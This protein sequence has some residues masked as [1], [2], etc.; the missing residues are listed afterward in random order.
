MSAV[1]PGRRIAMDHLERLR[2]FVAV[3]DTQSFAGAARRL[4]CSAP[5]ATRAIAALEQRLG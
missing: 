3:A 2:C 5:A 4:G 1:L